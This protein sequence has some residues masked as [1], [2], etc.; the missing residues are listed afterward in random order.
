MVDGFVSDGTTG[1]SR[2]ITAIDSGNSNLQTGDYAI[3]YDQSSFA[4]GVTP[5]YFLVYNGQSGVTGTNN[6]S[7]HPFTFVPDDN[8]ASGLWSEARLGFQYDSGASNYFLATGSASGNTP[9]AV[10]LSTGENLFSIHG[11]GDVSIGAGSSPNAILHIND[12][13]VL[14]GGGSAGHLYLTSND[15]QDQDKG[16][17]LTFGGVYTGS[18]QTPFSAI[19][20]AKE[21]NTGGNYAGYLAFYTRAHGS[22]ATEEMRI[23]STGQI[24]TYGNTF[25]YGDNLGDIWSAWSSAYSVAVSSSAI[26]YL[27]AGRHAFYGSSVADANRLLILGDSGA[28][29]FAYG[30]G[31]ATGNTS[32]AIGLTSGENLFKIDGAGN[33]IVGPPS[34]ASIKRFEV[35]GSGNAATMRCLGNN[36]VKMDFGALDTQDAGYFGTNS[37]HPVMIITSNSTRG[38]FGTS[39]ASLQIGH[40]SNEPRVAFDLKMPSSVS[41]FRITES[42]GNEYFDIYISAGGSVNFVDDDGDIPFIITDNA[43]SNSVIIQPD[44]GLALGASGQSIFVSPTDNKLYFSDS[45]GTDHA[46][47]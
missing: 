13:T 18:S 34:A 40:G 42:S 27:S 39:S 14:P 16:G 20:G 4:S 10:A 15:S 30:S 3:F 8:P 37:A 11:N 25:N 38:M 1:T 31:S 7:T 35:H 19:V 46:L 47:Y 32:F 9:F 17:V 36:T 44:G 6:S 29:A 45:G 22:A 33:V 12:A 26:N 23:T 21:N 43:P 5:V 41:G 24:N 2:Y 28:S